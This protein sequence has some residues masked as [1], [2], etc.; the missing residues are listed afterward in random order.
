MDILFAPQNPAISRIAGT[1]NANMPVFL[2][3]FSVFW[4]LVSWGLL[5]GLIYAAL[6]DQ[7]LVREGT[8]LPGELLA[9]KGRTDSDGDFQLEVQ[10]GFTPPDSRHEFVTKTEKTQR[11]DLKRQHLPAKGTPVAVLY[12]NLDHYRML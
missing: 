8:L 11:N 10:Y 1:N 2:T 6:R 12:R 7:H 5:L 4:N 3:V 9:A